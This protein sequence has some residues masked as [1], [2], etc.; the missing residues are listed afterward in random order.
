MWNSFLQVHDSQNRQANYNQ[1]NVTK[2]KQILPP[3][4]HPSSPPL[5]SHSHLMPS[6]GLLALVYIVFIEA[7]VSN[8]DVIKEY[9]TQVNTNTSQKKHLW[10]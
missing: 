3:S 6:L 5:P 1:V 8:D 7:R 2:A 9:K 4:L 10:L